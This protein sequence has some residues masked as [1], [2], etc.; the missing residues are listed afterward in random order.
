MKHFFKPRAS[1]L[2]MT[3][4][5]F[6]GGSQTALA[7]GTAS[8][9]TISNTATVNYEVD[10]V[11]QTAVLSSPDGLSPL[12]L[13]T[14]FVV[15]NKV[16]VTVATSDL[17]YVQV[18]PGSFLQV[19]TYTVTNEGNTAQDFILTATPGLDTFGGADNF[20]ATTAQVFVETAGGA[21]YQ[22][23]VDVATFIDELAPTTTATPLS[24]TVYVVSAIDAGQINGDIAAYT[25]TANAADAGTPLV[26]GGETI[27]TGGADTAGVDVV[28]A[29]DAGVIDSAEEGDFSATSAYLVATAA[30]SVAKVS[31]VTNDPVNGGTNPKAIPGATMDYTITVTN[32]GA[33]ADSVVVTDPVPTNTTFVGSSVTAAGATIAYSE[34]NETTYIAIPTNPALVT[35]VRA[36]FASLADGTSGATVATVTFQVTID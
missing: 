3:A 16:D 5:L 23:G 36:T 29:D 30:L 8:N 32:T 21:G 11:A 1:G 33:Q 27:A 24:V 28:L 2:L 20:N 31:A 19:L 26:L 18:A 12:G 15:D 17:T 6:V 25:L 22:D 14:D 34:D 13:A 35:H 9:T 7:L 10:S 4:M